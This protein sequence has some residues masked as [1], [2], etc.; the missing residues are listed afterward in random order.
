MLKITFSFALAIGF[1]KLPNAQSLRYP[2]ALPYAAVT[3]Y[4]TQQIDPLSFTGNPAALARIKH[5]GMGIYGERRFMLSP[6]SYY[7]TAASIPTP[8]GKMGISF[9]YGGYKNFNENKIALAY[10]KKLGTT[11]DMGIQF[12]YYSYRIPAY[13]STGSFTATVA[14]LL[15]LS[16][17]LHT[18]IYVYNPISSK[19]QKNSSLQMASEKQIWLYK[20]GLGYDASEAFYCSAEMMKEEDRPINVTAAIQ[21]HFVK[22]IFCRAGVLTESGT[23]FAGLGFSIGKMRLDISGSFHPQLGI[24]PGILL[25]SQ[26]GK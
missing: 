4:S 1:C 5:V 14:A 22:R 6:L 3:A 8:I 16:E 2:I 26:W 10:A 12:N 25:V 18:G 15:H 17:K 13:A 7:A 20:L 19:K 9:N 21:Y 24:S 23:C 11:V